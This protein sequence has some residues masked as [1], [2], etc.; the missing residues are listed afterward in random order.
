MDKSGQN[1]DSF[2]DSEIELKSSTD[3]GQLSNFT[4]EIF[5]QVELS[6]ARYIHN[7]CYSDTS[8]EL[9]GVLLGKYSEKDGQYFVFIEAAVEARYTEAK[10]GSVTFTHKSWDYIN[11]IREDKYPQHKVVGWFHTHP[12]FGIFLSGYD[13]FIHQNFFNLPF[14]VA[15]VVDPLA[16]KHG[17]FGWRNNNLEVVSFEG[18]PTPQPVKKAEI[19]TEEEKMPAY[20]YS[21]LLLAAS[22]AG[23]LILNGYFYFT[24]LEA[25]QELRRINM[26]IGEQEQDLAA[27]DQE[28]DSLREEVSL[29]EKSTA[30]GELIAEV[31]DR[32]EKQP[33]FYEYTIK[34]GDHLWAISEEH[35][36]DPKYYRVI[37][38]LNEIEDPDIIEIGQTIRI[39]ADIGVFI[40]DN[41]E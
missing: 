13:K 21:R 6:T 12:G 17:F 11:K 25:E 32:I 37:A 22:F 14:Q 24:G 18:P 3:K 36:G 34:A 9:A 16:G 40:H 38:V 29:L 8:Q 10:R 39:P 5:V 2:P 23:L 4:G 31:D 35:L 30:G 26:I 19:A 41:P 15:Y 33:L 7:Y 20:P 27:K 1:G 28:I